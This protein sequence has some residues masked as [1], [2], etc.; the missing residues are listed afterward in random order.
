MSPVL[1]KLSIQ[2]ARHQ[3]HEFDESV[4]FGK[5]VMQ[6]FDVY[7]WAGEVLLTETFQRVSPTISVETD[8]KLIWVSATD[9]DFISE[10]TYQGEVDRLFGL[11]KTAGSIT[12]DTQSFSSAEA[13][14]AL[15]FFVAGQHDELLSL[16]RQ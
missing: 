3:H 10:Y 4:V 13:R 14:R 7:D 2:Y 11:W 8:D 15:E 16:Y 1:F 5:D 12:V 6:A 9:L